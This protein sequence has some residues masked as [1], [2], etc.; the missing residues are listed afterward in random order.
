MELLHPYLPLRG[1][2]AIV[3]K[4]HPL[5]HHVLQSLQRQ[6]PLQTHHLPLLL[7][8]VDR[9]SSEIERMVEWLFRN[10]I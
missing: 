4:L 8:Q 2:L 9:G 6:T 7:L 1:H 10:A 3:V 5:H